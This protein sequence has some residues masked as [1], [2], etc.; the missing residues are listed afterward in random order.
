MRTI[1]LTLFLSFLLLQINA[2]C[3]ENVSDFGNNTSTQSYN[4]SGDVS[5]TLNTNNTVSLNLGSNFSTAAGPDVRAYLV[6]SEGKSTTEIKS[7]SK[8]TNNQLIFNGGSSVDHFQ[9]G[10]INASGAQNLTVSIP[11]GKNIAD[12]DKIF[13]FCLQFGAFWDFGTYTS[14]NQNSCSILSI[15]NIEL[16]NIKFYPNPAKN[17]IQF[18]NT[19]AIS[20]EIRI[21]N[22]LGKQVFHQSNISEKTIDTSS[23]N[24]GIYL[25]KIDI[26][27]KTKTQKLVIQ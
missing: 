5:I 8:D 9:F 6:N 10:L 16:D 4:I 18:S 24:K 11:E 14:F 27:G 17:K 7:I 2:Q 26:D 23:F 19:N 21:F 12:Y 25:V 13:F 22:L 3:S 15:E 20:T 1:L